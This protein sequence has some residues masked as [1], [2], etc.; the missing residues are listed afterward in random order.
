MT[1]TKQ[2]INSPER[3]EKSPVFDQILLGSSIIVLLGAI[4][5]LIT[6]L[7]KPAPVQSLPGQ[8][9]LAAQNIPIQNKITADPMLLERGGATWTITPRATYQISARVLGNRAYSD[10]Q[11]PLVPRDLAL[12]WGDMSDPA[13]DE[14][15]RWRQSGRWY[16]Y[17]WPADSP[18]KNNNIRN[19]SANVHII[20]A[21]DNLA[22]M[23][24]NL[25]RDDMIY[26]EGHLVDL[27][28]TIMGTE[29][30]TNTSLS[31]KDS[32]GGACEILYVEKLIFEGQV[33]E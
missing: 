32:G 23:L 9:P 31:R 12:G 20:P 1:T 27:S 18:Y 21:N 28:A 3:T 13:V 2:L 15:I 10:W 25:S 14:W 30:R 6:F 22:Q 24:K 16:Y 17:N 26:L 8:A 19:Q 11:A 33:Y 5:I 7:L 29:R 4:A